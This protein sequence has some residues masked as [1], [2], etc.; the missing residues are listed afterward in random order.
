MPLLTCSNA[1]SKVGGAE[2][3][4][5]SLKAIRLGGIISLVGN[6]GSKDA[7]E[8]PFHPME[9]FASQ[10]TL[11]SI[12]VGNRQ[13]FLDLL[14]AIQVNNIKPVIDENV[15]K[16]SQLKEAYQYMVCCPCFLA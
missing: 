12:A 5:Q 9:I 15:F 13:D 11:R 4:R 1:L 8:P 2:S 6:V 3:L 10:A 14:R 16:M 7:L